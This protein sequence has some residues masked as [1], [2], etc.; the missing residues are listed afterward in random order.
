MAEQSFSRPVKVDRLPREGVTQSIEATPVERA[1][2]ARQHGLADVALLTATFNLHRAG[3]YVRVLGS[4]HAELTQSCV[5]SL[6]P[7][8]VTL[9]EPVDVRFAAPGVEKPGASGVA[10]TLALDAEDPPDPII[11]GK[12][13]LG[14][15]A[16][17]FM[18]LGL[19]PYPR[20][21]GVEFTPLAP[22]E[23]LESPFDAL[24]K[25]VKR[26]G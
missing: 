19:D 17:E 23:T 16:V 18:A 20:K 14:A 4:V 8:P 10:E 24:G 13:D 6:E 22:D 26:D 15:L 11:D 21:P 2:I 9:D 3:R 1:A 25:I 12:I 5:V 7:F